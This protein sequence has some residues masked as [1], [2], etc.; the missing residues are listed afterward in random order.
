MFSGRIP[1]KIWVVLDS[2]GKIIHHSANPDNVPIMRKYVDSAQA[3][4]DGW[5]MLEYELALGKSSS[6][7]D[8]RDSRG[9][10]TSLTKEG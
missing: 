1:R 10:M 9:L 3:I 4:G 7:G 2:S 8:T 5:I 6:P